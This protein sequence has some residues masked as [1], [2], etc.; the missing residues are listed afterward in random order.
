[1]VGAPPRLRDQ[2]HMAGVERAH[3]RHEG[4]RAAALAQRGER[5]AQRV[6]VTDDLHRLMGSDRG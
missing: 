3:G 5:L 2:R 1:M 4:D 6:G